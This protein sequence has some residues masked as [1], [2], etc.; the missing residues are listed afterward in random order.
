[1]HDLVKGAIAQLGERYTGSVE[2][3]G[4]IPSSS[5]NYMSGDDLHRP[6]NPSFAGFFLFMK[7]PRLAVLILLN[8][9]RKGGMS[10]GIYILFR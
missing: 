5:T 4:S 6:P 3:D 7:C 9:R 1:M 10:G 8:F 2:V